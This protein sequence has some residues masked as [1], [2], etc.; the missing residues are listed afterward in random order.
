MAPYGVDLCSPEA[1]SVCSLCS[2]LSGRCR[3]AGIP[4][5]SRLW[6]GHHTNS[7]FPAGRGGVHMT[8]KGLPRVAAAAGTARF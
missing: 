4:A 7:V 5:G 2:V 8:A 6:R 1:A 3:R